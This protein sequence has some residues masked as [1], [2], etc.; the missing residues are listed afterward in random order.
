MF[1]VGEI[2][3]INYF[4]FYWDLLCYNGVSV[5]QKM[6]NCGFIIMDWMDSTYTVPCNTDVD[7]HCYVWCQKLFHVVVKLPTKN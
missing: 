6:M 1:L 5:Y 3:I 4:I 7:L 2:V